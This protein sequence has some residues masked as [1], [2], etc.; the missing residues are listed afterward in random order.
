[1][2]SADDREKKHGSQKRQRSKKFSIACTPDEYAA[3]C[4]RAANAG[5]S[6]AA[7]L[8]A[9]A[10]GDSGPRARRS[11]PVNSALLIESMVALNRIGNNLNQIAHQLNAGGSPDRALLLDSRAELSATL[12]VILD[13]LGRA[14]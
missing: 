5:L 6:T 13:A 10:L 2:S 3:T 9:C 12:Q 14:E 7:Y 4:A 11:L 8:R 1:M